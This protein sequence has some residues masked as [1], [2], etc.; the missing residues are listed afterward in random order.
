MYWGLGTGD[1][2]LGTG[3]WGLGTGDW[4]LGTGDW[5]LEGNKKFN[6]KMLDDLLVEE[7]A[8]AYLK[9][10]DGSISQFAIAALAFP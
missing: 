2:G 8:H 4:G 10:G 1:W 5:K 3:D 9:R 6:Y 7:E